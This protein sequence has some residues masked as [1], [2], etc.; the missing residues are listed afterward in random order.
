[1]DNSFW[2]GTQG[3]LPRIHWHYKVWSHAAELTAGYNNTRNSDAYLPIPKMLAKDGVVFN[4]TCTEMKDREQAGHANCS[5]E[6]LVHQVKM[7]T[8]TAGAELAGKNALKRYASDAYAQVLSTSR[9]DCHSGLTA[10]TYLR[11]TKRLFEVDNWRHLV[12]FVISMSEGGRRQ[13]LPHSDFL[14]VMGKSKELRRSTHKRLL[15]CE[16]IY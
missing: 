4:F 6:G 5:S 13:R 8:T 12:E 16:C 15:L 10:F 1:M 2:N 9:S 7:A 3:R 14:G 11:M